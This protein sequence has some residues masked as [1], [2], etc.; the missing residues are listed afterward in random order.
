MKIKYSDIGVGF[1]IQRQSPE[2]L[3]DMPRYTQMDHRGKQ[4]QPVV[5]RMQWASIDA[6]VF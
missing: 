3:F 5:M 6:K 4:Q 2:G 1:K